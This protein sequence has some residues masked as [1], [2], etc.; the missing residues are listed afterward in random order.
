MLELE[1]V[2][3]AGLAEALQD[4]STQWW[5]DPRTGELEPRSEDFGS[6]SGDEHPFDRG[7]RLVEPIEPSEAYGDMEDFVETVRD[8]RA[9]DLLER[10][11][12]G[13]GAFR[14]FKD[15][16]Y[17]FPDL[18]AAW[19]ALADARM[20]RRAL[21]WLADEGLVDRE[22]AERAAGERSDPSPPGGGDA[23]AV[24][25]AAAA[26]LQVLYGPRLHRLI[27]YGSA[28]RGDSDPESDIDLLVVLGDMRSS[29]EERAR[30]DDIL[31]RLSQE[32]GTVVSAMPVRHVDVL[33]ARRPLLARALAEGIDIG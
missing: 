7:L 31:W 23:R 13:R 26:E 33:E 32:H 20:A 19:F 8:P 12:S 3:L 1:R 15:A 21:Y 6:E 22:I 17:E 24:A 18:R 5:F 27:L 16:L 25:A 4:R 10:A 29:W 14:R 2:D 11:I 28:A 9:R 30:M